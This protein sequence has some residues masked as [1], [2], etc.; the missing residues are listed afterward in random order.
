MPPASPICRLAVRLQRVREL[1][2]R[3]VTFCL[4]LRNCGCQLGSSLFCLR[5]GLYPALR[6]IAPR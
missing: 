6:W 3:C 5:P 1:A 2:D 4:Q